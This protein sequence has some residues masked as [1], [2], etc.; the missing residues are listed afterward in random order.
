M[1]TKLTDNRK[2]KALVE[3]DPSFEGIFFAG[4]KTTGIFCRPTC[5][6]RKPK[7]ENVDFFPST[8]EA[9]VRG[10]RPCKVCRPMEP[11]G[12]SPSWMG[13]ILQKL[14]EDTSLRFGDGDIRHL[15]IDPNRVR[16]NLEKQRQSCAKLWFSTRTKPKKQTGFSVGGD[17]SAS[18]WPSPKTHMC[19]TQAKSTPCLRSSHQPLPRL[20]VTSFDHWL[21]CDRQKGAINTPSETTLLKQAPISDSSLNDPIKID[22]SGPTR[23]RR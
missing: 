23:R 12:E 13:T 11:Q 16:R 17:F 2:Y 8:K 6:A 19:T 7:R 10:F 14:N 18:P 15:G 22:C 20:L 5:R 3:K 4:V 9:L 21:K 1:K